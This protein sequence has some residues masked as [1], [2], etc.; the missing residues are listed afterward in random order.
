MFALSVSSVPRARTDTSVP[1]YQLPATRAEIRKKRGMFI[2]RERPFFCVTWGKGDRGRFGRCAENA[3][4][5]TKFKRNIV[6][7]GHGYICKLI[8]LNRNIDYRNCKWGTT[9]GN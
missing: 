5:L 7:E 3:E 9:K 6:N 4:I 2:Y 1:D 8:K